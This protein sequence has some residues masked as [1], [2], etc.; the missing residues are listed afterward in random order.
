M[1]SATFGPRL[2]ALRRQSG[3]SQ[4]ELARI[5]GFES[6]IS[7]AKLEHSK[8][9][10]SLF[11]AIAYEII[12]RTQIST[13]FRE[14][15]TSVESTVEARMAKLEESFNDSEAKGRSAA[16]IARKLEFLNLRRNFKQPY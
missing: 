15:Y 13:Q 2:R 7:V 14:L 9:A 10:P 1:G 16:A 8:M 3:L 11:S 5:L 6:V 12:F 4:M